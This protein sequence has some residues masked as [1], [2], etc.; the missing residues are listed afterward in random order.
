MAA[1]KVVEKF[2]IEV[3]TKKSTKK[4]D[5][6]KQKAYEEAKAKAEARHK[7]EKEQ[8][9]E[10]E[11]FFRERMLRKVMVV[12]LE[13]HIDD[14]N[15]C[16]PYWDYMCDNEITHLE[17]FEYIPKFLIWQHDSIYASMPDGKDKVYRDAMIRE[18]KKEIR[19]KG[20]DLFIAPFVKAATDKMFYN[21]VPAKY[22]D[23]ETGKFKLKKVQKCEWDSCEIIKEIR[24]YHA[25]AALKLL[26]YPIQKAV[27]EI[28]EYFNN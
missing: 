12:W 1:K 7:K 21:L 26:D 20:K 14:F 11:K 27:D 4:V 17:L 3:P 16:N 6:A 22:Q 23:P 25:K 15:E 9:K 18:A 28:N 19:K 24:Q 8:A 5:P 13:T 10:D 2:T